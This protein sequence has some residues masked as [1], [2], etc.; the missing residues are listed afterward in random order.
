MSKKTMKFKTELEQLL[1]LITH[2]LY[3]HREIFLRELISNA[4]DAVDKARFEG[5]TTPEILE[6]A[7]EW[8]IVVRPDKAA[9]TL[10]ISDNGIGMTSED[11]VKHLGTIAHSGTKAF[12]ERAKDVDVEGNPELIGQF[13]VGFY[14]A[15]MV[16][17]RVEVISRAHGAPAVKW[18]SVG[19]GKFTVSDA[20]RAE[21]GTDV[22]LHLKEDALDYLEPWTIRSAVKKFSDFVEHPIFLVSKEKNDKDEE[23]EKKE[24]I[25]SGKAIWLRRKSEISEEEYAE[26]YKLIA[27]DASAPAETIHYNAEG[28]IEFKALL[29][30]PE[31]KP[32][33]LLWGDDRKAHL[34]LYVRRVFIGNDFESLLPGYLRF[35]KGVVDSSDLPLN[36][37]R[38]I[39][40]DNPLLTK[41][42][43]NLVSRI[44]KTLAEM[45]KKQYDRFLRFHDEFASILKE[46]LESDWENREKIADLLLFESTGKPAGE[47]TSFADYLE[48]AG[49]EQKE[50]FYLCG[51]S[52]AA[53]EN[54]PYLESFRE[55][56]VEVLLMTDPIDDFVIPQLG[57]YKGKKLKAVNKGEL[58]EQDEKAL[59]KERK[60]YKA[61]LEKAKE[62]IGSGVGEVRLSARLKES[63][64]CLVA[65]EAAMSPHV[66]EMVRRM[67]HDVPKSEAVLELNP[68]HP[69]VEKTLALFEADKDD[70]KLEIYLR[71]LRDQAV[72]AA[73]AKLDDPAGFAKRLN[74]VLADA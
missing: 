16:A 31:K 40:Q 13:G 50:I 55:R 22:V 71:L 62:L 64:S 66:E 61:L 3:S 73:G 74:A 65:N 53:I 5:L 2:S 49:E 34:S 35:V 59:E 38:E 58:D 26:F 29:F 25:N 41:I 45:K 68:A 23:E 46:G 15:F 43:K 12:L 39:L 14:S 8:R 44:L 47:K 28:A 19:A 6:D 4:C 69:V 20:E 60:R 17:E 30:V 33:D 7:S 18:E 11:V 51:E 70:P 9:K 36:V 54:A 42:R 27:R 37:S 67:G 52:R 56:D 57:E 32:F 24:R 21:R 63:A 10:T 48:R 72:V 1:H